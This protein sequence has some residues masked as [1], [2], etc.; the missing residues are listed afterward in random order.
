MGRSNSTGPFPSLHPQEIVS[1][2]RT[3][4][5]FPACVVSSSATRV[6]KLRP[7]SVCSSQVNDSTQIVRHPSNAITSTQIQMR[8]FWTGASSVGSGDIRQ[9]GD[10][11]SSSPGPNAPDCRG[12]AGQVDA[13]G[14]SDRFRACKSAP[15]FSQNRAPDEFC[16]A[17]FGHV[18]NTLPLQRLSSNDRIL[19]LQWRRPFPRS[20]FI[21]RSMRG[22]RASRKPFPIR[23]IESAVKKIIIPGKKTLDGFVM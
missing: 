7:E 22:S 20:A 13:A 17:Q 11:G 15:Q 6:W 14:G 19:N 2:L 8:R 21:Y 16:Q 3:Q 10:V 9:P 1:R 12:G 23:L 18:I 4:N 5:Y